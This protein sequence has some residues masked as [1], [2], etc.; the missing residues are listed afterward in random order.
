MF[1]KLL[2]GETSLSLLPGSLP[3]EFCAKESLLAARL[4]RHL[5]PEF[6]AALSFTFSAL[7]ARSDSTPK[8]ICL[9]SQAT[10]SAF[11]FTSYAA[12]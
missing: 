2:F 7:V 6:G 8:G 1:A 12:D 5:S 11:R 3:R 10:N 4:G 9:A